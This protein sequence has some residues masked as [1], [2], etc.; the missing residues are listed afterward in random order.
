MSAIAFSK[1]VSEQTEDRR[2]KGELT[3][4]DLGQPQSLVLP[5]CSLMITSTVAHS[6]LW[7]VKVLIVLKSFFVC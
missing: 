6:S 1:P 7:E 5:L 2:R 4:Y 3:S